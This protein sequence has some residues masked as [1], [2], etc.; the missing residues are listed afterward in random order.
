MTAIEH[1]R[2]AHKK[3]ELRVK[4]QVVAGFVIFRRTEE[5]IKFL[6]LYRRGDY[7]NFPKGH[8]EHGERSMQT[9]L[10]ET[11]EET[12]IKKNELRIV[13][14]FKAYE[15]FYFQ[16]GKEKIHDTVILYLAETKQAEVRIAP[17]EHSGFAWFLYHDAL[18]TIGRRYG[19]IRRVLKQANDFIRAGERHRHQRRD[20]EKRKVEHGEERQRVQ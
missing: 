11:E 13:P 4:R 19:G 10:R 17:R 18:K 16:R 9:A 12:G 3:Q 8:F 5:G 14:G 6:F 20:Q 7:W 2:K 15:R 1:P